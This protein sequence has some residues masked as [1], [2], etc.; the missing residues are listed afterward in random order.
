MVPPF[1]E[2]PMPD[3]TPQPTPT[4][5]HLN[6][7]PQRY[8]AIASTLRGEVPRLL[9]DLR[10]GLDW[11]AVMRR[12]A[13]DTPVRLVAIPDLTIEDVI[14]LWIRSR[15]DLSADTRMRYRRL[16]RPV[17]ISIG[18]TKIRNLGSIVARDWA[19]ATCG[20]RQIRILLR[21]AFDYGVREGLIDRNPLR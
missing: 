8:V 6:P 14:G 5:F 21:S 19:E 15:R 10:R 20:P 4:V 2:D 1:Q 13:P 11:M 3:P 16:L 7:T 18:A 17:V 12:Y 9:P